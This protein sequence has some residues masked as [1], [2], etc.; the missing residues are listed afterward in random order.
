[1]FRP[2]L[3]AGYWNLIVIREKKKNSFVSFYMVSQ[4]SNPLIDWKP[5]SFVFAHMFVLT[6]ENPYFH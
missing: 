5:Q 1:M 6:K 3:I 4:K 2:A